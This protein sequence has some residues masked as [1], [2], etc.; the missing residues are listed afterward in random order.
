[1]KRTFSEIRFKGK[2]AP[3]YQIVNNK[4]YFK[5]DGQVI[6]FPYRYIRYPDFY[7]VNEELFITKN[8]STEGENLDLE[9][10]VFFNTSGDELIILAS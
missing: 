6:V 1:M 3:H 4:C 8:G 7:V 10:L 9:S 5:K 2:T